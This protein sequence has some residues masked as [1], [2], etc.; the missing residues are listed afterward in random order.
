MSEDLGNTKQGTTFAHLG[1]GRVLSVP[2]KGVILKD[3]GKGIESSSCPGHL[4]GN[5]MQAVKTTS[6]NLSMPNSA[7]SM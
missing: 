2:D 7:L 3:S 5:F 4:H 1:L 6:E